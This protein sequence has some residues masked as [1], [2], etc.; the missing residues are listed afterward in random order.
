MGEAQLSVVLSGPTLAQRTEASRGQPIPSAI[1]Y[2]L[3][4]HI[5]NERGFEAG[6]SQV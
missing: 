5:P 6:A 2:M 1:M 4:H 3:H